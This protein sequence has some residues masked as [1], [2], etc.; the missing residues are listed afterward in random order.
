MQICTP[1][2]RP[3]FGRSHCNCINGS[4]RRGH[5]PSKSLL[6]GNSLA[7]MS[8]QRKVSYLGILPY[9]IVRDCTD[10]KAW[11]GKVMESKLLYR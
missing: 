2:A 4:Q 5:D 1:S 7:R 10:D 6:Y 3:P 9:L 8:V 11:I